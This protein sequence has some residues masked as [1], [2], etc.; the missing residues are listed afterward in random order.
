MKKTLSV[1]IILLLLFNTLG[2]ELL[3]SFILVQCKEDASQEMKILG[4]KNELQML[5]I[6][7]KDASG[8]IRLNDREIKYHGELFDVYKEEKTGSAILI[9]CYQDKK[10]QKLFDE[11]QEI[12]KEDKNNSTKKSA[13]KFVLNNLLKNYLNAGSFD[14][15]RRIRYEKFSNAENNLYKSLLITDI[16]HPPKPHFC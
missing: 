6:E 14:I 2:F 3:F 13:A 12:V 4:E 1:I 15:R 16:T 5:R 9:Y 7:K 10:E 8:L 11:L